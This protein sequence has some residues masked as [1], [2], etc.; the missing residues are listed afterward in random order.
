MPIVLEVSQFCNSETFF[1]FFFFS[2]IST[3]VFA[4]F[5]DR[6]GGLADSTLL[7]REVIWFFVDIKLPP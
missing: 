6:I 4:D 7:L 3:G 5:L 2:G 1:V